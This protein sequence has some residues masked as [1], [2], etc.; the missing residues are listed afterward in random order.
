MSD[1]V[2]NELEQMMKEENINYFCI[3][4]KYTLF[5]DKG[6]PILNIEIEKG[7]YLIRYVNLYIDDNDER[8]YDRDNYNYHIE[9]SADHVYR[10]YYY[11]N[12]EFM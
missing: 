10:V 2:P 9:G 5:S 1:K 8:Y 12:M 3:N 11:R 6:F 4:G 7:G